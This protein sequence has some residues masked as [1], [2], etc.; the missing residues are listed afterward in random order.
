VAESGKSG[1]TRSVAD[2]ARRLED[3]WGGTFGDE[4]IA[5]NTRAGDVRAP[6]WRSI[7]AEFP[8]SRVLEV[9]CN[10]GGNLRWLA[11]ALPRGGAVGI[12][13]SHPALVEL[14]A[15]APALAIRSV[16]RALPF[17]DAAF[18]LVFTMGVLIHQPEQTLRDVM[19]EI[20]R[21]ARRWVL[22]GEYHASATTEVPYRGQE[23]ALFKRDYGALYQRLFPQLR[24][25]RRWFF[26]RDVGWD[27]VSIWMFEK[28]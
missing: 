16:A 3:L 11:E 7:S 25:C 1:P 6:F 14:A 21:C 15:R 23:G 13:V 8:A 18:D 26:G 4:Y 19:S 17:R 20:V 22:C 2:E 27:D 9:G 10:V 5:R 12:D 28:R 24:L